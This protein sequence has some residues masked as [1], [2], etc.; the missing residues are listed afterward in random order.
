MKK[1]G[2]S[3]I[4][5][6]TD[7]HGLI[8]V[9]DY[10]KVIRSMHFG[11]ATQQSGMYLYN[12]VNLLHP[13][14]QAM[15]SITAIQPPERVLLLGVGGGSMIKFLLHHFPHVLIDAIE[16]RQT[17][18]DVAVEYFDLPV[19]SKRLTVHVTDFKN[20]LKTASQ[21]VRQY[22]LIIIDLFSV[23]DNGN[24]A[25]QLDEQIKSIKSLLTADGMIAINVLHGSIDAL[26][27]LDELKTLFAGT[28]YEIPVD[29]ANTI[30]LAGMKLFKD[31]RSDMELQFYESKTS[32][33]AR[34]FIRHM[35]RIG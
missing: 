10:K 1:Y 24:I 20:Y 26:S 30:A 9:V 35:L 3:L 4:Y 31:F 7:E 19:K 14:T 11:N 13:Y 16:L 12:P 34:K 28:L 33:A 18:V 22:D 2:G 21:H 25:I 8:E 15:L 23:D 5:Q 17:V 6:T 27:S 32:L 29:G